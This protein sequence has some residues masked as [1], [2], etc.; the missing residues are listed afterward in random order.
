MAE[1]ADEEGTVGARLLLIR[2]ALRSRRS[3]LS[4]R[5]LAARLNAQEGVDDFDATKLSLVER[6][7]R[8]VTLDEVAALARIDPLRRGRLWV[9]WGDGKGRDPM[10]DV[11]PAVDLTPPL[12]FQPA[13]K[14][15]PKRA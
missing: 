5:E 3:P 11:P 7:E 1:D 8:R 9:G 12:K 14:R 10:Y 4:L 13:P 6:G 2:E 15:R